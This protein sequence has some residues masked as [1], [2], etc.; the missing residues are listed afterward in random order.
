MAA[1]PDGADCVPYAF[2]ATQYSVSDIGYLALASRTY[3]SIGFE[4]L[5]DG[6]SIRE[7]TPH[8]VISDF[9]FEDAQ[10]C[11]PRL[12]DPY[13]LWIDFELWQLSPA[14]EQTVGD[15]PTQPLEA[16]LI[17]SYVMAHQ[18]DLIALFHRVEAMRT[19]ALGEQVNFLGPREWTVPIP[20]LDE[21][22][23]WASNL[24]TGE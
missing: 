6:I 17:T 12:P 13:E 18:H 9:P 4:L 15:A 7:G 23:A 16:D 20:T 1:A 5:I 14:L 22:N 21:L 3:T 19:I 8:L 2:R 24:A 10:D 11:T